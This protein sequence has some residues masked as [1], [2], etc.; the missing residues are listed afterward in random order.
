M[1][2][3]ERHKRMMDYIYDRDADGEEEY[4]QCEGCPT[5][6]FGLYTVKFKKRKSATLC[7]KCIKALREELS[8]L[9]KEMKDV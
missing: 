6:D 4:L 3:S 1:C 9:E 2:Y 8:E 5:K 7:A